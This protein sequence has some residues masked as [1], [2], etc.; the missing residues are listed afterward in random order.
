MRNI[1]YT[2]CNNNS[3]IHDNNDN[4][5][6]NNNISNNSSNNDNHNKN[7]NDNNSNTRSRLC[8]LFIGCSNNNFSNLHFVIS[9][10]PRQRLQASS[11]MQTNAAEQALFYF[12]FMKRRLLK[13]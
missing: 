7:D 10:E 6:N 3:N 9:L 8:T 13:L 12:E 11:E 2:N 4:T 1:N 5:N